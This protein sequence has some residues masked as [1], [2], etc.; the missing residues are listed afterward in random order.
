MWNGESP[1]TRQ[2][3]LLKLRH[4]LEKEGYVFVELV[5]MGSQLQ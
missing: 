2:K 3:D 1:E 5:P 4:A